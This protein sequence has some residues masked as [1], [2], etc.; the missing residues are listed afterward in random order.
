MMTG[1]EN[2]KDE[3][4]GANPLLGYNSRVQ[5]YGNVIGQGRHYNR[6][7]VQA[8]LGYQVMH[9]GWLEVNYFSRQNKIVSEDSENTAII[10]LGFRLNID[11]VKYEF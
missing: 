7:L 8:S 6:T 10:S 3:N 1:G 5:D 9:N 4:W 11:R 2:R